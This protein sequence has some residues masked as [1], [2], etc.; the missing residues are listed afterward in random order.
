MHGLGQKLV[1]R[2]GKAKLKEKNIGK[3]FFVWIWEWGRRWGMGSATFFT[4]FLETFSCL[5]L[6]VCLCVCQHVDGW[7]AEFCKNIGK[8]LP[9]SPRLDLSVGQEM[10]DGFNH[11]LP[12]WLAFDVVFV[13]IIQCICP[14]CK[15]YFIWSQKKSGFFIL[16]WIWVWGGQEMR[17]GLSHA[18]LSWFPRRSNLLTRRE[19][20]LFE[21]KKDY[22]FYLLEKF[23][24]HHT[25][26]NFV[27]IRKT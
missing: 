2:I 15:M 17:D 27:H 21:T 5:C 8:F 26:L 10:R 3:F 25:S 1:G 9:L 4:F 12:S 13:Q 19:E 16:V 7:K 23:V 24:W 11:S 6:C 22:F 20:V 14:N 18:L